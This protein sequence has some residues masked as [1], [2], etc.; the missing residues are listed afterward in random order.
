MGYVQQNRCQYWCVCVYLREGIS[1]GEQHILRFQV[2]VN[3]VLKVQVPQ[4]YENLPMKVHKQDMKVSKKKAFDCRVVMC[5]NP[6]RGVIY[7]IHTTSSP[8]WWGIWW[9]SRGVCLSHWRGSS[10]ACRH[11]ASPSQQTLSPAS[12]TCTPGSRCLSDVNPGRGLR[13][14]KKRAFHVKCLKNVVNEIGVKGWGR[15]TECWRDI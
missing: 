8:V 12:Q 11:G 14:G 15:E 3:D 9:A 5:G 7:R 13:G 2:T 4:R 6:K 1:R 10:P